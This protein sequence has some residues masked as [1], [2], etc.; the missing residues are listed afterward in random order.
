MRA[1]LLDGHS[2]G[3]LS[4]ASARADLP[5]APLLR[6]TLW[7]LL[8]GYMPWGYADRKWETAARQRRDAYR[9]L[10]Q[11]HFMRPKVCRETVCLRM[12]DSSL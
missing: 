5:H 1:A 7:R 8:L 4:A 2:A 10:V 11:E 3:A 6:S 12:C 9:S